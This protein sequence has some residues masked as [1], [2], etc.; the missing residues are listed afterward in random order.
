MTLVSGLPHDELPKLL[1]AHLLA[2]QALSTADL[3]RAAQVCDETAQPLGPLLLKLGMLSDDDLVAAYAA[4]LGCDMTAAADYPREPVVHDALREDFLREAHIVPLKLTD[5][6]LE[7]ATADPENA[8]ALSALR[9]ALGR[10]VAIKLA[11]LNEVERQCDLLYGKASRNADDQQPE[12]MAPHEV[13][14]VARLRDLA[15]D[16]PI[17]SL[18]NRLIEK[19]IESRSSD[20]HVEP[21]ENRLRIRYRVDGMLRDAESAPLRS[22]PAIVSRIKLMANMNIAERRLP[23]DGRIQFRFRGK[24]I[25]LRVSSL[26]TIF[27]E[28]VVLRVLDRDS[29]KL[30]LAVLGFPDRM[31]EQLRQLLAVPN[32]IVLVTGPTGSGKTTTLY[33]ALRHLNTADCKILTVEDPVEYL[34][35]GVN[36]IPARP[37][38]G[39]D[40]A[41]VLRS[42][43]RQDPD[44]IMVGEMRDLET[45]RI[46][47]RSALTGHLV[48]ST[49]H[50]NDA[51]SSV[52][53]LV[54]MGIEPFLVTSTVCGILA[55]RLV[56]CLCAGCRAPIAA[57][58]DVLADR[59]ASHGLRFDECTFYRPSGCE[60][61]N[62]TGFRGRVV[63]G[64]LLVM[65]GA[66]RHAVLSRADGASLQRSA[67]EAGM[68]PMALDGLRKAAAGT[69]TIEEVGRVAFF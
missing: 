21:F 3:K 37:E 59:L 35:D 51:G 4:V 62:G 1:G 29:V 46:A 10:P 63:I 68:E 17:V 65:S 45:S 30:D 20:I 50:T 7:V 16:A 47:V 8:F 18:V 9:M 34:L 54:D 13:D 66:V 55:Q 12:E 11:A 44:V 14:D 27:G 26:P 5:D 15:V 57:P 42:M 19:A 33:A 67:I 2:K 41:T 39:L 32:G 61:C 48:L 43:V 36:Q 23:Q 25:D 24:T 6:L 56:R 58:S 40:F 60:A 49:L 69:T 38:I 22:A 31:A 64:E 28:S 53:R 52:T